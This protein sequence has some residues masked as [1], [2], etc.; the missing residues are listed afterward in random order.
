VVGGV[1]E[2]LLGDEDLVLLDRLGG[3]LGR[4]VGR[5]RLVELREQEVPL[6]VGRVELR[7]DLEGGGSSL[8]VLEAGPVD[9]REVAPQRDLQVALRRSAAGA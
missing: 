2:R 7:G 1:A 9:L 5:E 6:D 8:E 4:V 3:E